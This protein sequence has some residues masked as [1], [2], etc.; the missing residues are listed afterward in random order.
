MTSMDFDGIVYDRQA[1]EEFYFSCTTANT[2]TS[3]LRQRTLTVSAELDH[4]IA[5]QDDI[6]TESEDDDEASTL[7]AVSNTRPFY[8]DHHLQTAITREAE[9][10]NRLKKFREK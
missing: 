9:L 6:A 3:E 1:L 4:L 8:V 7:L 5:D 2:T 10:V